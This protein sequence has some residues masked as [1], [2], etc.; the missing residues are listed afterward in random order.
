MPA[1]EEQQQTRPNITTKGSKTLTHEELDDRWNV[2]LA[3]QERLRKLFPFLTE[4]E[5]YF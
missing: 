4:D 1:T 3:N 2:G 5:G